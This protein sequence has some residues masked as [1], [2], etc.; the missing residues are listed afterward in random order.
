M[1]LK[2]NFLRYLGLASVIALGACSAL[3]SPIQPLIYDFGP[4]L[5][6]PAQPGDMRPPIVLADVEAIGALDSTAV[7][8]RLAYSDA[9]QV[10]PYAQARWS[11]PP[12]Q[13]MR[14]RLRE[15]LGRD[16]TVLGLSEG[17]AAGRS[18]L[19]LRVTLE[20]FSQVFESAQQ[21]QGWVRVRATLSHS[22]ASGE[23]LR[24]Q[25][26]FEIHQPSA[27]ADAQGGVRALTQ[28]TDAVIAE[29]QA[30]LNEEAAA[31]QHTPHK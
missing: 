26:A 31:L 17:V 20:E 27:S 30:W 11:M 5:A 24:A 23:R 22:E 3:Q 13:L 8:Y 12:A 29:L 6:S 28:A 14:Q 16:R 7:L 4:G 19:S 25:R 2:R 21:N 10:R 18:A 9:Q 15:T 1:T